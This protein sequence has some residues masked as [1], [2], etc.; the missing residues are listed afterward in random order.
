MTTPPRRRSESEVGKQLTQA[1]ESL[2]WSLRQ[3]E[4]ES[5][6]SNSYISQIER[7]DVEPSPD[8]LRRLGAAY[9]IPFEVLME[10][11]GYV[12]KR[13]EPKQPGKVPAFVFS[14]AEKMDESDWEAAQAFF[15]SLLRI[16]KKDWEPEP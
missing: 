7:G 12:V 3:A 11:A 13:T 14:A 1:R 10:A 5:G 8:V 2:G 6:V 16:R 9:G 15:Q 4:R